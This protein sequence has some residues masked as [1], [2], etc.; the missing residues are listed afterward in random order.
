MR[1]GLMYWV[2]S[3]YLSIFTV[4][5]FMTGNAALKNVVAT[6]QTL[7]SIPNFT[8]LSSFFTSS[9][10]MIGKTKSIFETLGQVFLLYEPTLF[11]GNLREVWWFFIFPL[12][13][14]MVIA[15]IFALKGN[16]S[17]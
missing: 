5:R 8:D 6:A 2:I 14:A 1:P 3:F 9:I 15:L 13:V 7:L 17:Y 11:G 10:T 16:K 12:D 4:E